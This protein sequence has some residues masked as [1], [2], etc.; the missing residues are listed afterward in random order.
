[1]ITE[2]YKKSFSTLNDAQ[3]EA[4]E[5]IEGAVMVIAGPGT[6]KTQ[7]LTLRIANILLQTQINPENILAL[8]FTE[9][10]VTA[11]RNRL[12][13]LIG[14]PAYRVNINTFHGFC[15]EIIKKNSEEFE[16]LISSEHIS[17]VDQIGIIEEIFENE[18]LKL[19]RP[20][21]DTLYYL[22]PALNAI[23]ELKKEG[24]SVEEFEKAILKSEEDFQQIPDLYYDKGVSIGKM[25]G[26]YSELQKSINKNKEL[27]LIY[28]AYQKILFERKLFD[29]NDMLL[30]VVKCFQRNKDLLLTLQEQYQYFLVDEHQDTNASQ[31]K[32]V[33]LICSFYDNPNLFV[34]GDEK[35]AIYRF[36]GASLENFLYFKHL[37]PEAKLIHLE[38]NYRS[39]QTILDAAGTI[40]QKNVIA[41][42]LLP[43][44]VDLISQA[45]HENELLKVVACS[46]YYSEYY[47][48]GEEIKKKIAKGVMPGSIAVLGRKNKDVLPLENVF[49]Y[50][51]IPYAIE[52][53]QNIITDSFIQKLLLLFKL[54]NDL[55]SNEALIKVLHIDT[56][57]ISPLDIYKIMDLAKKEKKTVWEVIEED[58][59]KNL[60]LKTKEQ[61][62]NFI[63][64][65]LEWKTV[66]NNESFD[67]LFVSVLNKSG[68]FASIL[69]RKNSVDLFER[70]TTLY[71]DVKVRITKKP[72][73]NLNDFVNYISLIEQHKLVIKKSSR[74]NRKNVIHLMTAH[75]SKGQEF[76]FVYIINA[77]DGQWGNGWQGQNLFKLPWDNLR[78]NLANITTSEQERN[79]DER[80]LFYV[81][82]TR[83]K[84]EVIISYSKKGLDGRDHLP[85]QFLSEML[86]IH[87]KEVDI[88]DFEKR[89]FE[90]KHTIL[91]SRDTS[92]KP[93]DNFME[94]KEFFAELFKQSGLN[95]SALNN[96]L[97]CPWKY[98]FRNL[99][100]IP[101]VRNRSAILGMAIH[102]AL[103]V[104]IN[105]LGT[106]APSLELMHK[107]FQESIE[108][109]SISPREKEELLEEGIQMLDGYY[110][111][112]AS[113]WEKGL[114]SEFQVKGVKLSENVLIRGNIDMIAPLA[115]N[116]QFIVCDFKT[117]KAKS[118]NTIEGLTYN[119][120]GNYKRQLVFYKLL[121]EKFYEGK[122]KMSNGV[123]EF[124]KPNDYGQYKREV[125][126]IKQEEVDYLEKQLLEVAD[127]IM[128]LSFW[129]KKCKKTLKG[130]NCE[131]CVLRSY[132]EG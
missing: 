45:G 131:Y 102:K 62:E 67:K 1:M 95:V 33:E 15:N 31:N 41:N 64:L 22:R 114:I 36:Q 51:E 3:K 110:K 71:D 116:K 74:S 87:K 86:D 20:T 120:D 7:I 122:K 112:R 78:V 125:F 19:L 111:E 109:E 77:Y 84:K 104:Y 75:K 79:E 132:I 127:E 123:I 5:T 126:E 49:E 81:A 47:F 44:E 72:S 4:V 56:L 70:V 103:S 85:S 32:I 94:H 83:A 98:F 53:D 57:G 52:S 43:K 18:K 40:I 48:I 80:R 23:G 6:G 113:T 14:T 26:K 97:E 24:I 8:T 60:S 124:I 69:A 11:M 65:L 58:S 119:A 76:D 17:E 35:Q 89:F 38:N 9:S 13:D 118:R 91:A 39:C 88:E 25:K 28:R 63:N 34:V 21:G 100:V 101:D 66:S 50:L 59:Y 37:Y 2:N 121:L 73:F 42:S 130:D 68:L 128:N 107:S 129:N 46:D 54:I 12:V 115:D 16:E 106:E 99:L 92:H 117:G 108:K 10:G 96:Y 55:G 30:E 27:F 105:K 29:Y 90:N 61:L 82:L 93:V